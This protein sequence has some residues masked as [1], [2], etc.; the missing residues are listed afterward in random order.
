MFWKSI[1]ERVILQLPDE[2]GW[3]ARRFEVL[4]APLHQP[5]SRTQKSPTS[6]ALAFNVW[7]ITTSFA[8]TASVD[9]P[10]GYD[11]LHGIYI[12]WNWNQWRG[13]GRIL[14][15]NPSLCEYKDD[16]CRFAHSYNHWAVFLILCIAFIP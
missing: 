10:N 9:A 7:Q 14:Q 11:W 16:I 6:P 2:R 15:L 4:P 8:K 5:A 3:Q 12:H 1:V 13:I